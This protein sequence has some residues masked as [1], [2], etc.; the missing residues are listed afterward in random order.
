MNPFCLQ[1]IYAV[2]QRIIFSVLKEE[3]GE[4]DEV[5]SIVLERQLSY[6]GEPEAFNGFLQYL[7]KGNPDSPW[8]EI[9]QVVRSSF[10][11][12]YRRG[13][14][15]LWPDEVIDDDFRDLVLKM[16]NLNPERRITAREA[17]EHRWFMD[18]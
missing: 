3:L 11:A 9:F 7:H 16:A 12:D 2:T 14:F 8:I 15:S 5:L 6:F 18:V 4:D 13:P 17:L 10:N 1:C